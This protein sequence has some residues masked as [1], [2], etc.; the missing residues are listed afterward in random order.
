MTLSRT[1]ISFEKAIYRVGFVFLILFVALAISLLTA[2]TIQR[3]ISRLIALTRRVELGEEPSPIERP[4]TREVQELSD[5]IS[6]M[7]TTLNERADYI[8]DFARSVSHEFKTP[9]TSLRGTVELLQDHIDTMSHDER[10]AFF[11]MIDH[12]AKRMERLVSGLLD[13]ARADVSEK[14]AEPIAIEEV[15]EAIQSSFGEQMLRYDGE[16]AEVAIGRDAAESVFSNLARNA[17]E[18]GATECRMVVRVDGDFL[19]VSVTDNGSGIDPRD[20]ERVFESFFTSKRDEGGTGLGLAIVRSLMHS[21]D[22]TLELSDS[23]T[24]G[25]TFLLRFPIAT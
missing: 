16:F 12:D 18:A 24:D 8:R 19:Q 7:A 6:N 20:H 11:Q 2:F 17:F 13:L 14:S 21:V 9:I 3:P 23:D 1:P 15:L 4:G 10:D 5:A 25:T 22:G